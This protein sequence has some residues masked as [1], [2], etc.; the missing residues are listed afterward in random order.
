MTMK[1][2]ERCIEVYGK[3]IYTFCLWLAK[4]QGHADDLYQDTFLTAIEV[5]DRIDSKENVKSYLLSISI[6]IWKNRKRKWAW[7]N[8][9]AP[10][11]EMAED[12]NVD[13]AYEEKDRVLEGER[14]A[15]LK[16]AIA[17]LPEKHRV[18]ILLYYMEELPQ[19]RIAEILHVP[20][21]TVKSRL[22]A[23]RKHLRSE[24]EGYF[25]E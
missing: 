6:R 1:E 19:E 18:M 15:V 20:I 7:R 22:Y 13:L 8:R 4:D 2:L 23:A 10:T 16:S 24:L 21:G 17:A 25:N 9:I 14:S 11:V 12:F 5:I 3:D